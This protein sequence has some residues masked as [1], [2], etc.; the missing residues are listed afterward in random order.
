V[1]KSTAA[2]VKQSSRFSSISIGLHWLMVTLLIVVYATVELKGLFPKG[3]DLRQALKPLH[4]GLGIAILILVTIRIA[5]NVFQVTPAILPK[6]PRWQH[7]SSKLMHCVLY[8]F[9][10]VVPVVGWLMMSAKGKP[11][12]FFGLDVPALIGPDRAFGK[13]LENLHETLAQAGYFLI[14]LHALAALFHHY[15]VRDNT[16]VRMLPTLKSEK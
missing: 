16:L 9:L 6:P 10:V 12:I 13:R 2:P 14:G 1:N 11:V 4:S 8:L 5:Y 3:S 15:I 7:L